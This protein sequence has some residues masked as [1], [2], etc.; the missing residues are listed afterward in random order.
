[1]HHSR[2]VDRPSAW[3]DVN[4]SAFTQCGAPASPAQ[5]TPAA[6]GQETRDDRRAASRPPG[7]GFLDA[8]LAGVLAVQ[9]GGLN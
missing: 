8:V 4:A 9:L 5:S 1:M 2:G 3:E 7:H 6:T